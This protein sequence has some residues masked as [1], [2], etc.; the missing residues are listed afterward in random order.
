MNIFERD[1]QLLC[2]HASIRHGRKLTNQKDMWNLTN[3]YLVRSLKCSKCHKQCDTETQ[4]QKHLGSEAC[5]K[6]TA[7]R[8]GKPYTAPGD[9]QVY[10]EVC[11]IPLRQANL[12]THNKSTKHRKN[13]L[14]QQNGGALE[15][16]CLVCNNE[17]TFVGKRAKRLLKRHCLTNKRHL[18]LLGI[19]KN[20]AKQIEM[21]NMY[22]L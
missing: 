19:P 20:Q 18:E 9:V 7:I 10:C 14:E 2:K 6:Q 17:K 3:E 5:R 22:Q 12:S 13:I 16:K 11:G 4:F 21:Y 1:R 8:L 15:F